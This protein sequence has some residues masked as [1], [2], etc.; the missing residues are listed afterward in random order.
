MSQVKENE[1]MDQQIQRVTEEIR[2]AQL[3]IAT[4]EAQLE[5]LKDQNNDPKEDT[6]IKKDS[7]DFKPSSTLDFDKEDGMF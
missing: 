3:H 5:K 4:L 7:S 1:T 2:L 6:H